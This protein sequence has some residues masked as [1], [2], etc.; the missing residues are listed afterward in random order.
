[1]KLTKL[2]NENSAND[3][4]LK[5]NRTTPSILLNDIIII[6]GKVNYSLIQTNSGSIICTKS[7][8]YFE[9]IIEDKRFIRA[10]KSHIVNSDYIRTHKHSRGVYKLV[11]KNGKVVDVARRRVELVNL[12]IG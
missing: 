11:L 1:M 2:I 10:H 12:Y 6:E 4:V 8:K 5:V 7:L 3:E 9:E